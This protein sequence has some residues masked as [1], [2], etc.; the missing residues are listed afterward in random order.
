MGYN[1]IMRLNDGGTWKTVE[2]GLTAKWQKYPTAEKCLKWQK[3][4]DGYK[5]LNSD[6]VQVICVSDKKLETLTGTV[7]DT[8][9]APASGG[10]AESAL[11]TG[12]AIILGLV[13]LAVVAVKLVKKM[14]NVQW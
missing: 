8:T 6:V 1:L 14:F 13:V 4:V 10:W 3:S 5:I 9:A 12:A 7:V 2:G 11:V